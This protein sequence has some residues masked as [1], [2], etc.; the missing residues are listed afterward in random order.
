[1]TDDESIRNRLIK[2]APRISKALVKGF[3]WF[4]LLYAVPM[5]IFSTAGIPVNLL[6]GYTQ[7]LGVYAAIV[8][9]SVVVA[10]LLSKTVFQ[11][12]FNMAKAIVLMVFFFYSLNG[13]LVAVN[14]GTVHIMVDL[15]VYLAM[16]LTIN[17][18]G[19]AKNALQTL[20]FLSER[21]E[22]SQPHVRE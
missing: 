20:D 21:A 1:L 14:L 6:P 3:V 4:L 11:H 16:L 13:G 7:L 15:R 10:E 5:F 19:L 22:T 12:A 17:F 2:A 8:V 18:L 9:F